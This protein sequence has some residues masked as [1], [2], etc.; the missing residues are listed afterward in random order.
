MDS[1]FRLMAANRVL[2]V[3]AVIGIVGLLVWGI[4]AYAN[5]ADRRT[6][7]KEKLGMREVLQRHGEASRKEAKNERERL[8]QRRRAIR[9]ARRAEIARKKKGGN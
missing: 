3:L 6:L 8:A 1:A 5:Y 4:R 2:A 9:M 7:E